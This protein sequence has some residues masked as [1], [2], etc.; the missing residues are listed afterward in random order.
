MGARIFGRS[1]CS[2][3]KVTLAAAFL[4]LLLS[5][6]FSIEAAAQ[7]AVLYK[8]Q[9]FTVR[10]KP[11][12]GANN[13]GDLQG[14]AIENRHFG[15]FVS[16]MEAHIHADMIGKRQWGLHLWRFRVPLDRHG[17]W[18]WGEDILRVGT[19][20]AA[21]TPALLVNNQIRTFDLA[22]MDSMVISIPD[23]SAAHPEL[24][25][26]AYG[27]RAGLPSKVDFHWTLKTRLEDR[28][29]QGEVK[30]SPA[31]GAVVAVGVIKGA[32]AFVRRDSL[33]AQLAMTGLPTYFN[34][35]ACLAV[36]SH[37]TW[38]RGFMDQEG[39]V[40]LRL[41]PD[42]EG[43]V[44]WTQGGSWIQEPSPVWRTAG[45]ETSWLPEPVGPGTGV[46]PRRPASK[47]SKIPP[48]GRSFALRRLDGRLIV[49]PR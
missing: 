29:M 33:R 31:S 14:P 49:E 32:Q 21:G 25:V 12:K 15:L 45:W 39:T 28:S 6:L 40:G 47:T 8:N 13:Y 46:H 19:T 3:G 30:V 41:A 48:V 4:L 2:N 7:A 11:V 43:V 22:Q 9:A 35:S 27:W 18:P 23:S 44:R 37:A 16:V 36:R 10:D 34:D 38:F 24:R 42:A 26:F 1:R 5:T 20:L 17:G